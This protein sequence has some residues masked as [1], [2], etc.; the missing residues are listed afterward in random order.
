[1]GVK[2]YTVHLPPL[3]KG[4]PHERARLDQAVLV[5]DG[6]SLLA[7]LAAPLWLIWHRQWLG[8]LLYCVALAVVQAL[9]G[10]LTGWAIGIVHFLAGT[11]FALEASSLRRWRLRTAGYTEVDAFLANNMAEA[12]IHFAARFGE[13]AN[14]PETL[15]HQLLAPS[16]PWLARGGE[17]GNADGHAAPDGVSPSPSSGR[18]PSIIGYN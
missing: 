3:D 15:K 6:F 18:P 16:N 9:T 4:I 10:I 1:M 8:L 2:A 11:W 12:D 7:F 14:N 17:A 5:A 13:Q